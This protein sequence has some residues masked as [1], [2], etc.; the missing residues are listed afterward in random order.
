MKLL[1]CKMKIGIGEKIRGLKEYQRR[2]KKNCKSS[3]MHLAT[4]IDWGYLNQI[5]IGLMKLGYPT[6]IDSLGQICKIN[7]L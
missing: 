2:C 1:E 5:R 3:E 7:S 4:S 6:P